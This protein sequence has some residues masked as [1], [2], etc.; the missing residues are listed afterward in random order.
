MELIN[1]LR[2]GHSQSSV[3]RKWPTGM[4]NL[5]VSAHRQAHPRWL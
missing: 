5:S 4:Y 1:R 3:I 2:I